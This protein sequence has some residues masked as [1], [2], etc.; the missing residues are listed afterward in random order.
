M[1]KSLEPAIPQVIQHKTGIYLAYNP[2]A[3]GVS[4][5]NNSLCFD[6]DGVVNRVT[7]IITGIQCTSKKDNISCVLRANLMLNPFD[8]TEEVLIPV[9]FEF[10]ADGINF[11]DSNNV[12][13]TYTSTE[14]L[15][16]TVQIKENLPYMTCGNCSSCNKCK[17][18]T[19]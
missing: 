9:T 18:Y 6:K 17:K 1:V 8:I 3:V 11:I 7:T 12:T 19:S 10:T 2:F 4:G 13:H 14:Y 15:F 5:D 16:E